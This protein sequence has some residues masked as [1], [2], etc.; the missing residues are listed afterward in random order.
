[1]WLHLACLQYDMALGQVRG[2]WTAHLSYLS[3]LPLYTCW[4]NIVNV[5]AAF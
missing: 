2:K 4:G 3:K 5:D 1:M